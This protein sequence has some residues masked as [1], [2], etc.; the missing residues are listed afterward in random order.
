MKDKL[1]A[2][3]ALFGFCGWLAG[4]RYREEETESLVETFCKENNLAAP[5]DGWENNLVH[6]SGE[7]SGPAT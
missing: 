2:S 1:T 5:R 4:R 6:P 7:C 3:E